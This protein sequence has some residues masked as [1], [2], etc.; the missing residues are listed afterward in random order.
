MIF[1]PVDLYEWQN[2]QP[3]SDKEQLRWQWE[4]LIPV[5]LSNRIGNHINFI[6]SQEIAR[7][8][9]AV[10]KM[11]LKVPVTDTQTV[12]DTEVYYTTKIEGAVT[13]RT[14]TNELHNGA[15]VLNNDYS[16]KMVR[17]CFQAVKYLN[18]YG[19]KL[20]EQIVL[21]AWK[22]LTADA[23]ENTELGAEGYRTS[24]AIQ[25]GMYT[26]APHIDIELLMKTFIA[27]T[28]VPRW[29]TCRL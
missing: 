23:C 28:I 3:Y 8:Q 2:Y 5:D 19:N 20:N 15:P 4:H 9:D 16:E 11:L 6:Y 26:P 14:R 7:L 13:T 22:L 29:M 27:F 18:I 1:T 12:L 24:S 25:I 21:Q 17:N 10:I